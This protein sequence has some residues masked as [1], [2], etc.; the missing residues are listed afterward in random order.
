MEKCASSAWHEDAIQ[1]PRTSFTLRH[2]SGKF[3]PILLA[4]SSGFNRS[5]NLEMPTRTII[6]EVVQAVQLAEIENIIFLL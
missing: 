6:K 3:T 5:P 4:S 2:Y 1:N